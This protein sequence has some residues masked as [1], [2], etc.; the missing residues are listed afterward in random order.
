MTRHPLKTGH[1]NETVLVGRDPS[2]ATY[3]CQQWIDPLWFEKN[4]DP[5]LVFWVGSSHGQIQTSSD[6]A[7]EVRDVAA[8]EYDLLKALDADREQFPPMSLPDLRPEALGLYV[9]AFADAQM[10]ST[11][12][13]LSEQVHEQSR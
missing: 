11:L 7:R 3:Y 4:E 9:K 5:M 2:L 12:Q 13:H 6:L 8:I 10:H 1:E